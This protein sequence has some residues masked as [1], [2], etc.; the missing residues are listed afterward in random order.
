MGSTPHRPPMDPLKR[1][2]AFQDD[3]P[4][5]EP[6]YYPYNEEQ[7]PTINTIH[8]DDR[9]PID[10]TRT[11]LMNQA[12]DPEPYFRD[13]LGRLPKPP[14]FP[15]G[16][17]IKYDILNPSAKL[18]IPENIMNYIIYITGMIVGTLGFSA[19]ATFVAP[20]GESFFAAGS[21]LLALASLAFGVTF[22]IV[23]INK[24]YEDHANK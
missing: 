15:D 21:F 10:L 4:I 19:L 14:E 18:T 16:D 7:E 12:N 8:P 6:Q 22:I 9:L 1:P 23:Q 20:P 24:D 2:L 13:S 5:G 3:P 17:I 11:P